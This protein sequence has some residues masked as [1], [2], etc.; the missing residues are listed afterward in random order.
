MSCNARDIHPPEAGLSFGVWR[1]R[2]LDQV[3]DDPEMTGDSVRVMYAVTRFLNSE[4]RSCFPGQLTLAE[5]AHVTMRTVQ[6]SIAKAQ[7]RGH[8]RASAAVGRKPRHLAP[9]LRDGRQQGGPEGEQEG[10]QT[11]RGS[12]EESM[13]CAPNSRDSQNSHNS[14]L[15]PHNTP[16]C[17]P[18]NEGPVQIAG[19]SEKGKK[20]P[21]RSKGQDRTDK[22]KRSNRS[23]PGTRLPTDWQPG[24]EDFALAK[25]EGIAD[26]RREVER[27]RDH[28][29]AQPGKK[30]FSLD[31]SRTWRNWVRTASDLVKRHQP[32]KKPQMMI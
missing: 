20:A 9:I 7:E 17:V 3:H 16:C 6:R 15:P 31:W 27:F 13:V 26:V 23:D 24:E 14:V 4:T 8:L 1:G 10:R 25:R 18:P 19:S 28:Y 29:L 2:W 21:S 32:P 12:L 5:K 22:A 11:F 30:G